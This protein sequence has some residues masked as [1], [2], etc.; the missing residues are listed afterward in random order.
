M[1]SRSGQQ[2][3][4]CYINHGLI[5]LYTPLRDNNKNQNVEWRTVR[6]ISKITQGATTGGKT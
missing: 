4:V 6:E 1:R 3:H 2:A 5:S